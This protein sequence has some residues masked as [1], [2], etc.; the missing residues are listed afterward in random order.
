MSDTVRLESTERFLA[1]LQGR[2][3]AVESGVG[4]SDARAELLNY[5]KSML[6]R[7]ETIK[8]QLIVDGAGKADAA[9][10]ADMQA[11][12]SE[13]ESLK[14]EVFQLKYRI[15]HLVREFGS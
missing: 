7:L 1:E 9:S 15:N 5:Q 6:S 3:T 2:M 4:T 10:N 11:L 12:Q 8:A 13:N 14:K